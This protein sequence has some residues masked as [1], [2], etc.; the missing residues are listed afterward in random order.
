MYLARFCYDVM[1]V[2]REQAIDFIRREVKAVEERGHNA[3]LLI[4]L[5]RG[6]DAAA[7]VY[8]VELASLDQLETIRQHGAGAQ[9]D[10]REWM[11]GFSEIL[12]RPPE[13]EILRVDGT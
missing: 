7:L 8:E 2:N 12:L 1:P 10:T 4:P 3:R 6:R 9:D 5:T 11:R 13:V